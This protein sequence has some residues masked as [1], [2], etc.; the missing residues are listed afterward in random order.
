LHSRN[1]AHRDIKPENI[2][3]DGDRLKL[4]D[5]GLSTEWTSAKTMMET[6]CG[7]PCY[8]APEMVAGKKYDCRKVDIWAMGVTLYAMLM[9]KLPFQHENT[10]KLYKLIE[11]SEFE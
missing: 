7:S 4:I 1:I 2:I 5:F 10:L 11:N 6:P 3:V 8:A 9:G